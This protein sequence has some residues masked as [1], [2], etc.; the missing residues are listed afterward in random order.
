MNLALG[1]HFNLQTE[2]TSSEHTFHV[3]LGANFFPSSGLALFQLC[4]HNLLEWLKSFLLGICLRFE[5]CDEVTPRSQNLFFLAK[6]QEPLIIAELHKNAVEVEMT[7]LWHLFNNGS[8]STMTTT[9]TEKGGSFCDRLDSNK[10]LGIE[11]A[12]YQ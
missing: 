9:T 10:I 1:I 8:D 7:N 3:A 2:S 5:L 12:A 4:E 6:T 11:S